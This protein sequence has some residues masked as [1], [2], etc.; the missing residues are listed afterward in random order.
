MEPEPEPEPEGETGL[1]VRSILSDNF[2]PAHNTGTVFLI[3]E[4]FDHKVS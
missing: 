3:T 4:P 2:R 1:E